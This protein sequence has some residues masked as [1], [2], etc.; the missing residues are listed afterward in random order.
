[1]SESGKA[2]TAAGST[3]DMR[4]LSHTL[5]SA[6]DAHSASVSDALPLKFAER[7][8]A[9]LAQQHL[10]GAFL[11]AGEHQPIHSAY[12][13]YSARS[14]QIYGILTQMLE[15]FEAEMSAS[16]KAELQARADYAALAKAK[17]AQIA[18]GKEKLDD[19]EEEH[20]ANQKALADA[21]E[22]LKLTREQRSE[23]VKFLQNLKLTCNDLDTQWERRSATR[24]AE[25]KAVT[26]AIAILTND[27]SREALNK[28]GQGFVLLQE[29]SRSARTRAVRARAAEALRRAA[30]TPD[31][32]ADD[33]LSEWQNRGGAHHGSSTSDARAQLSTLAL[34]VQ[35][36]S[37]TKVKEAMDKMVAELKSQQEEEAKFKAYCIKE[38]D[39]TEQATYK[40]TELKKDLEAKLEQ[41]A[42]LIAK[43]TKEIEE[44]NAQIASTQTEIKKA[45]GNREAENKEFQVLVVDQRTV[46]AILGKALLR[47]QDFYNKGIG[48]KMI[49]NLQQTPPVQF[50]KYKANSGASP[51]MGLIEQ[52]M[53]DSKQLES[54]ATAAEYKAQ[55]DYEKLVLDSNALITELNLMVTAKTKAIAATKVEVEETKSYLDSTIGEL[56]SLAAYDADL[57]SQCDFTLK[58]FDIRQKAR[59]QE[60]EAIQAA[61]AI[62]S[63]DEQATA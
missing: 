29:S 12:K 44:A 45:S 11:Q 14:S 60:I 2:P 41:L 5:L 63:G 19:M 13:S 4:G 35:L 59:L 61:K 16:Q 39:E 30:Q 23:D 56:E 21:N 3:D 1:M 22:D 8:V 40:K 58:N 62:L 52:I 33:L 38:L 31:F 6:L 28:A 10:S 46:Q 25:L 57:H 36:D 26:E 51:V 54:E 49:S 7:E 55:A 15:E 20:A 37:F 9:H 43:L 42:A 53:G 34:T 27:E 47:L 50:N 48:N 32:D 18:L 17:K 24:S